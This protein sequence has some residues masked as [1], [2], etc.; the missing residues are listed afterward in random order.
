[1]RAE[2]AKLAMMAIIIELILIYAINAV[3]LERLKLMQQ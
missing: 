1:M 3:L 2:N